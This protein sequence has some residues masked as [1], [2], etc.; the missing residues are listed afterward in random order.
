MANKIIVTLAHQHGLD[1]AKKRVRERLEKLQRDYM[2]KIA[3]SEISWS[4]DVADIRLKALGYAISAQILIME[5]SLRIEA[6][7]PWLLMALSSKAQALI[8]QN[9]QEALR[10]GHTPPKP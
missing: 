7:L 9:A 3:H 5:E 10:I 4:G 6:Q 8:T 2:G 1:G